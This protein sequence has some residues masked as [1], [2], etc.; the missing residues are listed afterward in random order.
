MTL[1]IPQTAKDTLIVAVKC[2]LVTVPTLLNGAIS[3]AFSVTP[4]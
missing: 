1:N 2:E 4:T 3:L